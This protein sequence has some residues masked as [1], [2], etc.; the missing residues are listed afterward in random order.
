MRIGMHS[1]RVVVGNIGFQGRVN[2]TA[3]GDAV[4]VAQRI[5]QAGK[6]FPVDDDVEILASEDMLAGIGEGATAVNLGR[7]A[8][9]GREEPITVYRLI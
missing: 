4:N 8:L 7:V 3:V 2:Y 9:R 1:G 6:D 5:E